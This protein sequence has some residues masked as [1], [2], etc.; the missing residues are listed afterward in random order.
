ME[1]KHV[2]KFSKALQG[3]FNKDGKLTG[4]GEIKYKNA[5]NKIAEDDFEE[6][7]VNK[8][9]DDY[10]FD[11]FAEALQS[12]VIEEEFEKMQKDFCEK[13]YKVFEEKDENKLEY[14]KIFN[15]YTKITE[16]FLEKEL[17]KRVKEYKVDEFYKLLE[18]KKFKIDEQLLDTLLDLS[19]FN[20]FKEMM[21][22]YKR[23]KENIKDKI[24][25]GIQVQKAPI[26]KQGKNFDNFDFL[27]N[28]FKNQKK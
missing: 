9:S 25:F 20:N 2:S 13:Y 17:A 23:E 26:N 3:Q 6:S 27:E 4:T 19:E 24:E 1:T 10:K 5:Q 14:T 21:L 8:D 7:I 16:E 12:I 28:N 18:T 22:N 11:I 15:E